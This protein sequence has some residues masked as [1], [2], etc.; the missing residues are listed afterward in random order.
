[1]RADFTK[2]QLNGFKLITNEEYENEDIK[3]VA[4]YCSE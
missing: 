3:Y 2:D 4:K 1:M